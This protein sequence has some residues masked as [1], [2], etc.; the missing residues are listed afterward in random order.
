MKSIYLPKKQNFLD[1]SWASRLVQTQDALSVAVLKYCELRAVKWPSH[2]HPHPPSLKE[3]EFLQSCETP[4]Q[5]GLLVK[6]A[7]N[8]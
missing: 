3:T 7:D 1:Y 8:K 6:E 2:V 4:K 5:P